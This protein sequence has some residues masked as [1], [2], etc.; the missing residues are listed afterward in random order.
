MSKRGYQA[1]PPVPRDQY[2]T[3]P[4]A[5]AP[6]LRHLRPATRFAEPCLAIGAD[7]PQLLDHLV[8]GGL[9]CVLRCTLPIDARVASYELEPG[10]IFCTNPPYFKL[11]RSPDLNQLIVNLSNQAESWL[12]L[13]W[14]YAANAGNAELMA[15]R[16]RGVVPIGRVVFFGATGGF[17]NSAWFNFGPSSPSNFTRL[18]PRPRLGEA[19]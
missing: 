17:E 4:E 18:Y 6:L 9:H 19:A 7:R 12:L 8:A 2:V 13:P 5:A 14:D 11:S 15:E 10:D 1:F 3:P 16:C